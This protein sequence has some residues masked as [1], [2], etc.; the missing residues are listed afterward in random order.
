MP[1]V[2][3]IHGGYWRAQ[4]TKI[5]MH[6]LAADIVRRG[7]SGLEHRLPAGRP[8]GWRRRMSPTPSS[9]P[10][11]RWIDQG[12]GGRDRPRPGWPCAAT[13]P[14]VSWPCGAPGVIRIAPG[15]ARG[16]VHRAARWPAG[17]TPRA[18]G[19]DRHGRGHRPGGVGQ[20]CTQGWAAWKPAYLGGWATRR[21]RAL[22]RRLTGGPAARWGV[23]QVLI[24]GTADPT[25]PAAMSE[26]YAERA[27]AL[28]DPV[29]CDLVEGADHR[30]MIDPAS[31]AWA[32]TVRHA[33][34]GS[35]VMR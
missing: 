32:R 24:H 31:P 11:P 7:W 29:V 9:T 19:G 1:V 13:R 15:D 10:P 28:G 23:P 34:G 4:Y 33:R 21:A 6:R 8:A 12:G 5:L 26:R 20:Q 14:V 16:A 35:G 2:V 3:L 17:G 18:A 30:S 22:C 25:V 27:R